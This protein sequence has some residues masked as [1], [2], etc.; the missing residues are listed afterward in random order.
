MTLTP[1]SLS[2]WH[3]ATVVRVAPL[4]PRIVSVFLEAPIRAPIAGQHLVVRLTA[5][6]GYAA[7]RSYSIAS[8]PAARSVELV[9]EKFEDGEV[10][11]F[12]HE[13]VQPGDAVD[14]RGPLGGHFVWRPEDGGPLLLVA[15]GSGMAPLMAMVRAWRDAA[16]ATPVLL[17]L[18]ARGWDDLAFR[19]E[20]I[21]LQARTPLFSFV[22]ATTREATRREGDLGRR[23]DG[24]ALQAAL[25]QW[26][27]APQ[28][29]YVCG[30]NRFV[31]AMATGLLEA[32]VA[33][34]RIR[35]ERYGGAG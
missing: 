16:S 6:D 22:A 25:R 29:A 23:F 8:S 26:G 5:P 24:P 18:S 11:P 3:E 20:L 32:G 28:H 15:G 12:F 10:S 14:V 30:A 34:A 1:P 13:V 9:I 27:H 33:A 19:D 21:A 31:E 17:L 4:T 2:P 35:T 7:Q